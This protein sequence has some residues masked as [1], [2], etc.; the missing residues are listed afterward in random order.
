MAAAEPHWRALEAADPLATPYQAFDFLNQWQRHIG[1]TEGVSPFIVVGFDGADSPMFV[2][3]FG[4]RRR[5]GLRLVEFMGGKH[6]NFNIALWRRDAAAAIGELELRAVLAQIGGQADLLTLANQ[7]VTWAGLANPFAQL[8]RQ[9]SPS[10]GHSG[11]LMPDFDAWLNAHTNSATRKKMRKKERTLAGFG[12][13]RFQKAVG[14][15]QIKATLASFFEQKCTRM[16]ALGLPDVYAEPGVRRLIES[17]ALSPTAEGGTVIELYALTLDGVVIATLGGMVGNGRFSGMFSS[18]VHGQYGAESPGEQLLVHLVQDLCRRG[19]QAFD[20][21]IGEARYKG[22][23]CPDA[24]PMFD[25]YWPLT[26]AGQVATAGLRLAGAAKR[27]VKQHPTL[28]AL[29]VKLRRLRG[30]LAGRR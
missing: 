13:V 27:T 22:L 29:I 10:F 9:A 15:E 6:A 5:F 28:W 17:A 14:L 25:S 23:F 8:P 19:L 30:R 20:L 1:A 2:W 26:P 4:L 3:P 12:D 7:P 16:R 11:A 24:D 18:I 21:G